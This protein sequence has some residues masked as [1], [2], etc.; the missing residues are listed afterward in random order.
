MKGIIILGPTATGKSE[1]A[2]KLA[3]SI[4][5]ELVCVDSRTVYRG[6]DIGT[7]KPSLEDRRK[8]PHHMLDILDPDQ[9]CRAG[10]FAGKGRKV[11]QEILSRGKRPVLVGGSGLYL[12]ALTKGLFQIELD[13]KERKAFAASIEELPTEELYSGLQAVDPPSAE[14]IHRNDRYR[15]VRALEV[16]KLSG[17]PISEH[18]RKQGE[19]GGLDLEMVKFGLNTSRKELHR[20][21]NAR[22]ASMFESGWP[23]EVEILLQN[24]ARPSWPGMRT[25]GYPEIISYL[26]G[27]EDYHQTVAEISAKTRQYAK[28]QLTWFRK[29]KGVRWLDIS[30]SDPWEDAIKVLDSE[31]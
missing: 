10:W 23:E 11:T 15:I 25:L 18:F 3:S 30:I 29:E 12:R 8:V 13:S 24:G 27:D 22:T 26:E 28:R 31:L 2:L 7:A 17:K 4:G 1:L 16:Y 14:R 9:K 19:E 5:G 20:R 6:L 21:I